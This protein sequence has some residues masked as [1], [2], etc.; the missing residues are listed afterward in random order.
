MD[1]FIINT[2]TAPLYIERDDIVS[3]EWDLL[4][5][6]IYRWCSRYATHDI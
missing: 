5:L 4:S 1:Y 2:Y 3:I 6:I